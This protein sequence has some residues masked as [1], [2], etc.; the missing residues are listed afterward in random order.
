MR[1]PFVCGNWK[2]FTDTRSGT[3]LATA[4]AAGVRDD[5]VAVAVCPPYPYLALIARDLEGSR[6]ALGAQNLYPA[7]EGAFTGEVSPAM[8]R[9]IGCDYVIVGHSERRHGLGEQNAFVD[10]KVLAGLEAG[11]KVIFCVGETLAERQKAQTE[12]IIYDQLVNGLK[13]ITVE[14]VTSLTIA[15][16]PVWA[17]G[18]GHNATPDQ[19]QAVHAFIRSLAEKYAGNEV[20]EKLLIIYGG[21]VK[22]E[23]AAALFAEPDVDGGLIG[24]ASL[25][26]DTFLAIVNAARTAA[27]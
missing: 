25:K 26:A 6:V 24:G 2:M 11:L 22:P 12:A 10:E 27:T 14:Q 5:A 21:S 13:G 8:L 4:V 19:A 17:I 20:A 16:E 15:Y 23:N 1:K 7:K 9:D 18:T 3:A